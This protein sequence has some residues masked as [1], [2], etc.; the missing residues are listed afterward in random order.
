MVSRA[1]FAGF[2][3]CLGSIEKGS[4]FGVRFSGRSRTYVLFGLLVFRLQKV[5]VVQVLERQ[6]C[7][8]VSTVKGSWVFD[9]P[10]LRQG[11]EDL[12]FCWFSGVSKIDGFWCASGFRRNTDE[13]EEQ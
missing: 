10:G 7:S 12:R 11:V 3:G 8:R 1:R 4:S 13:E 2:G 9:C 6:G 5:L